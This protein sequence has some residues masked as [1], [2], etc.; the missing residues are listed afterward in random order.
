MSAP[1]A[2][3]SE[4]PNDAE[5]AARKHAALVRGLRRYFH[6]HNIQ[7]FTLAVF[8]LVASAILWA[9]IYIFIYW[10][11]LVAATLARSFNPNTLLEINSPDLVG[12]NFPLYFA[13]GALLSLVIARLVRYRWRPERLRERRFY[14]LWILA[15]LF[16]SVPNATLAVWGNFS[17]I[18]RLRRRDAQAA[19]HLLESLEGSQEGLSLGSL[20]VEIED[21][22]TLGR[23]LF[24]LQLAGLVTVREKQRGWFLCLQKPETLAWLAGPASKKG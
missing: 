5:I 11:S 20:R 23:V 13:A 1:D 8:S 18:T 14:L 16:L 17:A 6:R 4:P 10:F 3:P 21:E 19:V 24:S 15:E 7:A 9:L 12:R 22:K 2:P